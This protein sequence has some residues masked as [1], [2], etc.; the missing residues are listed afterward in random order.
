MNNKITKV[1]M[2]RQSRHR[3]QDES[4]PWNRR[5]LVIFMEINEK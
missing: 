5:E 2:D 4:R 3:P 1:K